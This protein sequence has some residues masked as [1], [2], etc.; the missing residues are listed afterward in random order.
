M[1]DAVQ[2]THT[3]ALGPNETRMVPFEFL[4]DW[5]PLAADQ[6]IELSVSGDIIFDRDVELAICAGVGVDAS[7]MTIYYPSGLVTYPDPAIIYRIDGAELSPASV[8]H[9]GYTASVPVTTVESDTPDLEEDASVLGGASLYMTYLTPSAMDIN[10]IVGG[11]INSAGCDYDGSAGDLGSVSFYDTSTFD[12]LTSVLQ[13]V[14]PKNMGLV[15]RAGVITLLPRH[16]I[17]ESG[18]VTYTTEGDGSGAVITSHN[19]TLH[20]MADKATWAIISQDSAGTPMSMESDDALLDGSLSKA[21]GVPVRGATSDR[22]M[23]EYSLLAIGAGGEMVQK[24]TNVIEGS[25]TLAGYHT[26]A[27]DVNG[28]GGY[29]GGRPVRLVVP[30][31]AFD[32]VVVPTEITFKDGRTELKL[33]NI[34][35]ADRSEVANSMGLT[36]DAVSNSAYTETVHIFARIRDY[37]TDIMGGRVIMSSYPITLWAQ[38]TPISVTSSGTITVDSAGYCHVSAYL[39]PDPT[40]HP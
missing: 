35:T 34:R 24:R 27:W 17:D 15:D 10:A 12:T 6:R 36:E 29:A 4:L 14:R 8:P 9:S 37:Q 7:R 2:I 21:L 11:L 3:I 30:Q 19:L 13:F 1:G 38:G 33:D 16:T 23:G 39:A 28:D 31:Y 26:E 20:W 5:V 32:G 25:V 18:A 40:G 22:T